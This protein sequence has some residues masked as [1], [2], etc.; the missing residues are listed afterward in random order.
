VEPLSVVDLAG[1]LPRPGV[2]CTLADVVGSAPQSPGAKMWVWADGFKGTI[3]GGRFESLVLAE[4][5]RLLTN[6]KAGAVL[7]DYTLCREMGQCCG[8]KVKVLFEPC[9]RRRAV[10]V[11]G[12]G[13][14]GRAL[15][16]T[17]ND[18][19]LEV[20]VY[21][22][23]PEWAD[24][25]A[26]PASTHVVCSD[27]LPLALAAKYST[28]D[29]ACVLTHDHELDFRLVDILLD[30]PLGFLGLIGSEHKARTFRARLPAPRRGLWDASMHCPI[31]RK[32]PSK[33]PKAIAVEIAAQLLQEWAY[34]PSV[35]AEAPVVS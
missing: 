21:D 20:L 22:P 31:G 6:G 3:G 30:K 5:R 7:K 24:S 35:V 9:S 13:H 10:H 32:I 15:A 27:P 28:F 2:L 19:D 14:V 25:K 4:A 1:D 33:N 8:G 18:L 17:L 12:A 34:R 11:F 29:A 26:F 23:R 16:S